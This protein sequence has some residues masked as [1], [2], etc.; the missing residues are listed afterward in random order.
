M[1]Y[2]DYQNAR[3]A[4]WRILL[5]CGVECL[6]VRLNPVC[7]RLKIRVLSYGKNTEMIERANL[8]QAVRRTDGMTFYAGET[9]IVLFDEKVL[10]ARAKFTV[11]HEL[12]HIILGHVKPGVVTLANREPHPGDAPEERAANQFAARLLAPACVLWGLDIHTPEE[13]M[14]LCHI[15]RQAAQ[16]RAMRMEELYRRD[17]FLVSPMERKVYQQFQPFI[18]EYR[19]PLPGW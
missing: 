18:Q 12:G 6:P 3:D 2:R 10:P 4:A 19:H 5:D 11:A 14:E 15:S 7:R 13:I 16:F 9:P 1:D 8:S 17:K